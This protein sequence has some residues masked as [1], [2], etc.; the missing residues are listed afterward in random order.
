MKVDVSKAIL[1]VVAPIKKGRIKCPP[2]LDS[3]GIF[4][5]IPEL[6]IVRK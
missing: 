4:S 1:K 3:K 5:V 2:V 6:L